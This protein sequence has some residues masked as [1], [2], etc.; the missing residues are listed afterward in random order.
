M[1]KSKENLLG[2]YAF[3]VGVIL[4]VVLGL[5]QK[6][7]VGSANNSP[8]VVL[9]LLGVLV[10]FLNTGDK[11]SMVFL[12]ASVALVIVSGFGQSALIYVSSVPVLSSLSDILAAL[13]V[14]MVPATIIVALKAVFSMAKI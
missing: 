11:D 10:G 4:A 14:M 12:F 7:L 2:A 9:V 3:L 5:L 6:S 8:Y 1:V 13:L